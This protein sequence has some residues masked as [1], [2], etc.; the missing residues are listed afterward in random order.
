MWTWH[1]YVTSSFFWRYVNDLSCK[2]YNNSTP[3]I[4]QYR[5]ELKER[6]CVPSF[7]SPAAWHRYLTLKKTPNDLVNRSLC[8]LISIQ[9]GHWYLTF[10]K[11]VMC[12]YMTLRFLTRLTLFF[13]KPIPPPNPNWNLFYF[14]K[15]HIIFFIF[16]LILYMWLLKGNILELKLIPNAP[17]LL[18]QSFN[19]LNSILFLKM[20]Q[21][22][23]NSL[24]VEGQWLLPYSSCAA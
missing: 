4:D 7:F 15:R 9:T 17:P 11:G 18:L 14:G 3:G 10:V 16:W 21:Q 20:Q 13:S 23:E 1:H 5:P 24:K 12:V 19:T 6:V 2:L 8:S 22:E